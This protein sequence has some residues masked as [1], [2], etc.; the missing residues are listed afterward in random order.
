[1]PILLCSRELSTTPRPAVGKKRN[2]VGEMEI[3]S[4]HRNPFHT[5]DHMLH[6]QQL[7]THGKPWLGGPVGLECCPVHQ[8]VAGLI[9]GQGTCLG[10]GFDPWSGHV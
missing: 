8:K 4:L 9:P 2:E 6:K 1:M 10:C 3:R 7:K 5:C